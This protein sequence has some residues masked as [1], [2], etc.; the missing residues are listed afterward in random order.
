VVLALGI[1]GIPRWL[2]GSRLIIVSVSVSTV[3]WLLA[4]LSL[5]PGLLEYQAGTVLGNV[6]ME[7]QLDSARNVYY[8]EG[9]GH[10][11][12]F[13]VA[14]RRRVQT[15]TLDELTANDKLKVLFVTAR[16][17]E[18]ILERGLPFDVL[19]H[20]SDY[21]ISSPGWKFLD[22]STRPNELRGAYLL[23]IRPQ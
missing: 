13:D 1:W 3:F 12:S 22:P 9:G 11:A 2:G 4:N 8:L 21:D 18:M 10:T 6:V 20:S 14:I 5:Y 7:R 19:A 23:Q 15:L 16:G 17:H